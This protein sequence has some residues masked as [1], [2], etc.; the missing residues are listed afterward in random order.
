ML[1]YFVELLGHYLHSLRRQ[2]RCTARGTGGEHPGL[3][4]GPSPRFVYFLY[5]IT[6]IGYIEHPE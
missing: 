5:G 3:C 6:G 4:S 2:A 1:L